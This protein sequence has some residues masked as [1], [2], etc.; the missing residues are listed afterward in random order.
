MQIEIVS[1]LDSHSDGALEDYKG[2]LLSVEG[3]AKAL[4]WAIRKMGGGSSVLSVRVYVRTEEAEARVDFEVDRGCKASEL[5]RF[6]ERAIS[7]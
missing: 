7:A 6:F 2:S 5:S 4:K 1:G 3:A